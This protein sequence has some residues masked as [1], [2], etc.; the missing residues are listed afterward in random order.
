VPVPVPG[1]VVD[2]V[3]AVGEVVV[4]VVPGTTVLVGGPLDGALP[5]VVG[6]GYKSRRTGPVDPDCAYSYTIV[7]KPGTAGNGVYQGPAGVSPYPRVMVLHVAS[8]V[9]SGATAN[10]AVSQTSCLTLTAS[11][12]TTWTPS[13]PELVSEILSEPHTLLTNLMVYTAPD[14]SSPLR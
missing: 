7:N 9:L 4:V 14:S 2:D 8:I 10:I 1:T 13:A 11:P 6:A 12:T 5:V 3:G